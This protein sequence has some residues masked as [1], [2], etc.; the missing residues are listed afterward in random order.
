MPLKWAITLPMYSLLGFVYPVVTHWAWSSE[1]WLG[2]GF[3]ITHNNQTVNIA[4]RDF[5]GSGV[6]HLLGGTAALVGTA[7]LGPRIGRFHPGKKDV[8]V[9]FKGH[10]V[11]L[12]ALGAFI[13]IFGFFAFNGGSQVKLTSFHLWFMFHIKYY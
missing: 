5:A 13:L 12:A 6:V 11:P 7:F 4:Y 9:D 10:S 2:Q 1:G 8:H 3:D